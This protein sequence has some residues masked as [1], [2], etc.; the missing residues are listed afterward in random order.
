MMGQ[1]HLDVWLY[2]G[3]TIKDLYGI[4]KMGRGGEE[5]IHKNLVNYIQLLHI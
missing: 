1:L 4:K 3:M 2:H 5:E